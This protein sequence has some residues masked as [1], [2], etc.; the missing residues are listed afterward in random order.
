MFSI[1]WIRMTGRRTQKSPRPAPLRRGHEETKRLTATNAT[2]VD[3]DRLLRA[4]RQARRVVITLAKGEQPAGNVSLKPNSNQQVSST[5]SQPQ[6]PP[7]GQPSATF[8]RFSEL[9]PELRTMIW[10]QAMEDPRLIYVHLGVPGTGAVTTFDCFIMN[11]NYLDEAGNPRTSL[12]DTSSESSAEVLRIERGDASR[13]RWLGMLGIAQ[14]Y[15]TK[16]DLVYL[17]GL[18]DLGRTPPA[19]TNKIIPLSLVLGNILPRVM[20]NADVFVNY[21]NPDPG[22]EPENPINKA[23]ADLR[24]LDN[25]YA[26]LLADDPNGLP[27]P[28]LPESMVFMLGNFHLRWGIASPC[29]VP[30]HQ[31]EFIT[32]CCI[33]YDHLEIVADEDMDNW[34]EDNLVQYNDDLAGD[35][36]NWRIRLEI[37]PA[38]RAIWAGWRSQPDVATQVPR[39][40]FARIRPSE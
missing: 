37:V 3:I 12:L 31:E 36:P 25:Q 20:V 40:F 8:P 32:S 6:V 11:S 23:L 24:T 35:R 1:I 14:L 26:P 39:L 28:R 2:T 30:E 16:A 22:Q 18:K 9:A 17:G 4:I 5:T 7:G 38:I 33:H 29:N 15:P 21:F 13:A 19:D 27:R 10:E 34:M